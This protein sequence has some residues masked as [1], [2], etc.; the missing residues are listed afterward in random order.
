MSTSVRELA[1]ERCWFDE[2]NLWVRLTN[3]MTLGVPLARFPRL[4][5][6]SK[7]DRQA[8]ELSGGGTGIHWPGLDEDI[9]VAG[10]LAGR[11]DETRWGLA[12]RAKLG[13]LDD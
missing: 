11:G 7:R 2:D 6:A 5:Y 10:L 12:E 4:Y 1:A 8:F 13:S 9:S 3:G